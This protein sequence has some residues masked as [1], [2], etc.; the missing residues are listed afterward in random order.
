MAYAE[1]AD[2]YW[3]IFSHYVEGLKVILSGQNTSPSEQWKLACIMSDVMGEGEVY[4]VSVLKST[5]K[6]AIFSSFPTDFSKPSL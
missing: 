1:S 4:F 6:S 2:D 5:L 3:D